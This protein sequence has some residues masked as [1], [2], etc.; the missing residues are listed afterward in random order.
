MGRLLGVSRYARAGALRRS[1]SAPPR[2][3]LTAFIA[4]ALLIALVKTWTLLTGRTNPVDRMIN[5]AATPLVMAGNYTAD[6][7][8]SLGQVFRLP[9]LLRE[10][11]ALQSEN[12]LLQR[13]LAETELVRATNAQLSASLRLKEPGFREV[14]ATVISRPYDLWLEQ[15]II[16]AGRRDGVRPGH[17][18][19]NSQGVVGVVDKQVLES[20]AWVTLVTSPRFRL[21]AV[22]GQSATEGVIRGLDGHN[23]EMV[24]VGRRATPNPEAGN[25][26]LKLV[27]AGALIEVGEKVFSSGVVGSNEAVSVKRPRGI[28][29]G[30]VM[31]RNSDP[32]GFLDV[33]VVPAVNPGKINVVTV[34][35][36]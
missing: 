19:I 26:E 1:R 20:T 11:Q 6:G 30:T 12:E 29:I 5:A 27:K 31:H 2:R 7:L 13:Q 33:R 36:E 24:G 34:M 35:V 9:A 3:W 28:L 8:A 15:I 22:T 32:N 4:L 17:L 16:D 21:A 18:V 10:N 23:L 25:M 14:H